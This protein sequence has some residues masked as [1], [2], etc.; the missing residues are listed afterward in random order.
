MQKTYKLENFLFTD[1]HDSK[2]YPGHHSVLWLKLNAFTHLCLFKYALTKF[3]VLSLI[4]TKMV[5][6]VAKDLVAVEN[7][8]ATIPR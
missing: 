1:L 8:T 2:E 5:L 7:V 3:V 4:A 6:A